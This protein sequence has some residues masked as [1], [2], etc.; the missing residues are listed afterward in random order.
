MFVAFI[1]GSVFDF[2]VF[3]CFAGLFDLSKFRLRLNMHDFGIKLFYFHKFF[4]LQ[5]FF[6]LSLLGLCKFSH[7]LIFPNM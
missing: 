5:M 7:L 3:S 4:K 6:A 1:F 2:L